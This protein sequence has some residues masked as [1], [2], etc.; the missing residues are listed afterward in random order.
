MGRTWGIKSKMRLNFYALLSAVSL[1]ELSLG[2]MLTKDISTPELAETFAE[3]LDY[4][5][6]ELAQYQNNN[7]GNT[8]TRNGTGNSGSLATNKAL[9]TQQKNQRDATKQIAKDK[10][11][12]EKRAKD[13]KKKEN[14]KKKTAEKKTKQKAEKKKKAIEKVK[15]HEMQKFKA[16]YQK[17][18]LRKEKHLEQREIRAQEAEDQ[19]K[20]TPPPP[21]TIIPVPV[22][23]PVKPMRPPFP[24]D[25]I[26][27]MARGEAP[28]KKEVIVQPFPSVKQM[29]EMGPEKYTGSAKDVS[30]SKSKT[31]SKSD[32]KKDSKKDGDCPECAKKFAAANKR[33]GAGKMN[34]GNMGG[35]NSMGP[36]G[37]GS[38]MGMGMNS[39][40]MGGMNQMMGGMNPMMS[41]GM[42]GGMG[43]GGMNPMMGGAM[44]MDPMLM[45]LD[46]MPPRKSAVSKLGTPGTSIR[47]R[48]CCGGKCAR[49]AQT[50]T[51]AEPE[52]EELCQQQTEEDNALF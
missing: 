15:K 35:M 20:S 1:A 4:D 42:M 31:D 23:V 43:M 19:I 25:F 24:K 40:G 26:D 45:G 10:E 9:M 3:E 21:P 5:A 12:N 2:A 51:D 13:M 16:K 17:K 50:E 28:Y 29:K 41:G 14:E 47:G 18:L 8:L 46:G 33:L 36:M 38:G 34:G 7:R 37:M 52:T 30:C 27:K 39:M 6:T 32:S 11:K 48:G 49:F 22:P 44:G